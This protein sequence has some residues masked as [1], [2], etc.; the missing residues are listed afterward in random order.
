MRGE[1]LK[2]V[3]YEWNGWLLGGLDD[4]GGQCSTN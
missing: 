4:Y 3:A 2:V 1:R